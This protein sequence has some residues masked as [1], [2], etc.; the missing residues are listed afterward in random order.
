MVR[1]GPTSQARSA[2][3]L[4]IEA[5]YFPSNTSL[6]LGSSLLFRKQVAA[7]LALL[8]SFCLP[9]STQYIIPRPNSSDTIRIN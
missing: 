1:Y 5:F 7:V 8:L 3:G 4:P 2:I 6:Q 9:F